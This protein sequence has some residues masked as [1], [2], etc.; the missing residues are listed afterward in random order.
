MPDH[1]LVLVRGGL[2]EA[3]T[4]R[5]DAAAARVR[6]GE[7][8]ISVFG[9]ADEQALDLLAAERLNRFDVLTVTTVGAIRRAGLEILPTFRRPHYTILLPDLDGDLRR[10]LECHNEVRLNPH[11]QPPE[12]EP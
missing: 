8:G 7:Y 2:L 4:L 5:S 1:A 6:F 3:T 9:A 11:F 12:T 10:L